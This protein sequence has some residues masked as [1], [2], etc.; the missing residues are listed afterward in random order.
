MMDRPTDRE[1][2]RLSVQQ[3]SFRGFGNAPLLQEISFEAAAGECI[4]I[5]GATGAGK[6]TLLKLLNRLMECDRGRIL[7]EGREIHQIPAVALRQQILLVLQEPKLL[8]MTVR[9]AL[10]YPLQ[11]RGLSADLIAQRLQYG[12]DQL[13]IPT[14]WL[15]RTEVQLSQ[16]Q[17]QIIALAWALI[18]Q[19]RVLLCDEPTAALDPGHRQRLI[20]SLQELATTCSTTILVVNHQLDWLQQ[21]ATRMLYLKQG[22]LEQNGAA[23]KLDWVALEQ[24]LAQDHADAVE[25]WE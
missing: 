5:V 22:H 15:E 4:G 18:I 21:F 11:L 17:K 2:P 23:H 3:V 13:Q 12:L 10:S 24:Q 14:D 6:T 1:Q 8:G 19:P 25:E 7:F 9:Q 20:R 16:G